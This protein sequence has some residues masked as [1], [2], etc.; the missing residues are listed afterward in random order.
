MPPPLHDLRFNPKSSLY[1]IEENGILYRMHLEE[2]RSI[3]EYFRS[4]RGAFYP[5][6]ADWYRFIDNATRRRVLREGGVLIR[7]PGADGFYPDYEWAD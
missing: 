1:E 7:P 4:S 3:K 2:T 6:V 5:T